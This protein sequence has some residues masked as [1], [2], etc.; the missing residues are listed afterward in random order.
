MEDSAANATPPT[1]SKLP[2][3]QFDHFYRGGYR[4]G[5]L[6]NGP[7]G[8]MRPEEW[9]ASTTTRFGEST[10]G[11]SRLA[12]GTLLRDAIESDPVLWLGQS[13]YDRFGTSIEILVK[14]LDPDQRLPVHYHPDQ[15]FA[16]EKLHINHG[17]TEAW[18]VLDAPAHAR[19]GLG[20]N[21]AMTK[22]EV[23]GLVAAHDSQG[24]LDSLVFLE[25][26]AG[27]AIFVPAGVPHAIDSGIFVL[28]LQEP[29]DLSILLEWD[30]FAVDGDLDG[31]LNLGFDSA[32]DALRLS[33]LSEGE[34]SELV[35][36]FETDNEDV[37]SVFHAIADEFFRADF[38]PGN[39]EEIEAGFGVF[40]CLSGEGVLAAENAEPLMVSVGD[41]VVIPH[42]AGSFHLSG[43]AGILCRP[44][45]A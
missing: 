23:A 38:L 43:C 29:T 31:H 12:D 39:G 25:V 32:L 28:E 14:L 18:I 10:T 13:H 16:A 8:P 42:C 9:I 3:N 6:R 17:K 11:L 1:P 44:P 24:L 36:R 37:H 30:G 34:M 22:S 40:L 2:S 21:R 15:K 35:S 5:K 45:A 4:I 33:P 27:D 20:F 19:V 41:A 26:R 7:G